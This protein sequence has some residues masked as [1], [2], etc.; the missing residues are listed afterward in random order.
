LENEKSYKMLGVCQELSPTGA[1]QAGFARMYNA[2]RADG[3][4]EDEVINQLICALA[5]GRLYGNWP[6]A[7]QPATGSSNN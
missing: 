2:L 3:I 1:A 5:D 7:A 6:G 4:S